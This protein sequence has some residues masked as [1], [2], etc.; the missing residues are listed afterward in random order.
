MGQSKI[1][2]RQSLKNLKW[3]GLLKA[4]YW[5]CLPQILLVPFLNT[6]S[7]ISFSLK[8]EESKILGIHLEYSANWEGKPAT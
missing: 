5:G 6:F 1:C 4:V 7:H 3:Y 2:G 8:L